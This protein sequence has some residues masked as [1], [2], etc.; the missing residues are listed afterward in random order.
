ME[1]F[2][3]RKNS[4]SEEY[5]NLSSSELTKMSMKIYKA[6]MKN[7]E[8]NSDCTRNKGNILLEELI[9]VEK[10]SKKHSSEDMNESDAKRFKSMDDSL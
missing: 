3:K 6:E 9:S 1:W 5:P 8:N 7:T 2:S 10:D 4:L